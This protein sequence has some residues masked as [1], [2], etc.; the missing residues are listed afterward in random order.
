MYHVSYYRQFSTK[1]EEKNHKIDT[2]VR[3]NI[4]SEGTFLFCLDLKINVLTSSDTLSW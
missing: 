2:F 4:M 1:I 3:P